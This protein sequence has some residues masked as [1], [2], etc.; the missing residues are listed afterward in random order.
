MLTGGNR[1]FVPNMYDKESTK[2]NKRFF[3]HFDRLIPYLGF[4]H[5][6]IDYFLMKT[7]MRGLLRL[8]R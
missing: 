4:E 5:H 2:F 7:F 1:E 8:A 3:Y 6:P